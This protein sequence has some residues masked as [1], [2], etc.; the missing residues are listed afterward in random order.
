[1][2][3][4]IAHSLSGRWIFLVLAAAA[5]FQLLFSA[6]GVS[7]HGGIDSGQNPWTAWNWNPLPTLILLVAAYLY[8]TGLDRWE[9]PSHRISNWQKFSFF[10]GLFFIFLNRSSPLPPTIKSN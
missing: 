1:M 6:A 8:L 7:A 3:A 10:L 9:R 2:I 5:A 4:A